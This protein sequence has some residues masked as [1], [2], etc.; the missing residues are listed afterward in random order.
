MQDEVASVGIKAA[1]DKR[2]P[3]Q[4]RRLIGRR[5]LPLYVFQFAAMFDSIEYFFLLL[6]N[7]S[8]TSP[9]NGPGYD[10][11]AFNAVIAAALPHELSGGM[12]Q[13]VMIAIAMAAS[14]RLL[15]ADEPTTG[16]DVT[17]QAAI[18]ALLL[19]TR[20]LPWPASTATVLR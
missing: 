20:D 9:S 10:G 17:T 1:I 5:E 3:G 13:R 8:N 15:I 11:P 19:I 16:L 2:K 18:M 4:V 12:C 6:Y 7:G 14:P